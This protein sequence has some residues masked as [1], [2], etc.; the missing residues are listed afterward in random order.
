MVPVFKLG[1]L[2]VMSIFGVLGEKGE[3]IITGTL[4]LEIIDGLL[5]CEVKYLDLCV[6][7]LL[8]LPIGVGFLVTLGGALAA[9][10]FECVICLNPC[11]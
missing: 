7:C 3:N 8:A 11:R 4:L 10:A 1:F 2:A 6:S 9:E 5:W